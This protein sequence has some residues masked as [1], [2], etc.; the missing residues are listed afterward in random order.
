[1]K[2]RP[3]VQSIGTNIR[4]H[5]TPIAKQTEGKP[6]EDDVPML[7]EVK[8]LAGHTGTV[9]SVD[10]SSDG[11]LAVSCSGWPDGD[12]SLRLWDLKTGE[13]IHR[14][15]GHE[16]QVLRAFFSPDGKL[17]VSGGSD[18][19]ARIWDVETGQQ[20]SI[21]TGENVGWVHSVSFTPD[22][23]HVLVGHGN[24]SG[25]F[26]VRDVETGRVIGSLQAERGRDLAVAISP[27]GSRALTT[28]NNSVVVW[29]LRTRNKLQVLAGD[30]DKVSRAIH[31][32]VFASD[33]LRALTAGMDGTV[34]IWN[35]TTGQVM[36][37]FGG[38]QGGALS[39]RFTLDESHVV[40]GGHD[41]SV[42]VWDVESGKEVARRDNFSGSVWAVAV[43]PDGQHV[44]GAGGNRS[45]EAEST[46]FM[47]R[48]W[49]LPTMKP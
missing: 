16:G 35:T 23:A 12:E 28:R 13:Q 31:S 22:G 34:K 21:Y 38:H 24:D 27:D 47:L 48:L 40:S 20:K 43:T 29:D 25:T 3:K 26:D 17:V 30:E 18:R 46:D 8:R 2:G 4:I 5:S 15:V 39:A 9:T 37:Q 1:M 32:V 41:R 19:T 11:R 7:V 42:R 45:A 49:R 44:L 14:L 6:V 36:K 10:V 33:N